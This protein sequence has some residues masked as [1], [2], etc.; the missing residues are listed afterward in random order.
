MNLLKSFFV[1]QTNIDE[2]TVKK[3]IAEYR[4]LIS[5]LEDIDNGLDPEVAANLY[6]R[7]NIIEE[8][9]STLYPLIEAAKEKSELAKTAKE[10][11]N[12]AVEISYTKKVKQNQQ[13][14]KQQ[15]KSLN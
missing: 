14:K 6:D 1:F 9:L 10:E 4:T 7:L 11:A 8:D 15:K 2:E 13:K 5:L 3:K 12:K